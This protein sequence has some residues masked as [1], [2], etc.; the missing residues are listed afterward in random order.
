MPAAKQSAAPRARGLGFVALLALFLVALGLGAWWTAQSIVL[1]RTV[2]EGRTVADMA[3]NVG[4]WASQYGGVH[5]RTTGAGTT[6]PGAFLTRSVYAGASG[7][8]AVLQG[9]RSEDRASERGA[10]ERMEAYH[11]KNPA[12]IQREVADVI[13]ASG[14]KSRYRL[15]ARSVLNPNNAPGAFEREAMDAIDA[16]PGNDAKRQLEYW[17]VKSGQL[18][19]ARAVM[20]QPSCLKC[21]GNAE[22]APEFMR[23]NAQ[24]NGGGGYGYVAGKPAGIISVSV[25]MPD[26]G[27]ALSASLPPQAWVAIAVAVASGLALVVLALRRRR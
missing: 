24:F 11:W 12:L 27:S 2:S 23:T 18:L 26:T 7:D 4:R 6:I 8:A 22:A 20:A 19:Y 17:S 15:T 3:E 21:H 1:Q 16:L 5:V 25:P 10:M 13:A 9:L 14:S